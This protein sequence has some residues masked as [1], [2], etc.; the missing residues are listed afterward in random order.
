LTVAVQG[1]AGVASRWQQPTKM[2][3]EDHPEAYLQ[4]FEALANAVNR[5]GASCCHTLSAEEVMVYATLKTAI[6]NRVGATTEGFHQRLW[7]GRLGETEHPC[8]LAHR[9]HDYAVGWLDPGTNSKDWVAELVVME[10]FLEALGPVLGL[11]VW[12]QGPRTLD[13][14][15]TMAEI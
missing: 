7:E 5:G 6:L 3:A 15:V 9:L 11:W 13:K 10:Q 12:R 4:L 2:M 8:T 14:A 1:G